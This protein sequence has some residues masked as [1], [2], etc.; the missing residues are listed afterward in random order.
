MAPALGFSSDAELRRQGSEMFCAAHIGFVEYNALQTLRL[1]AEDTKSG[2]GLGPGATVDYTSLPK[3]VPRVI[4]ELFGVPLTEEASQAVLSVA[5]TYSKQTNPRT[6][7][8]SN[9]KGE[10]VSDS[11]KKRSTAPPIFLKAA[12]KLILPNRPQVEAFTLDSAIELR[13]A[14]AAKRAEPE[15]MTADQWKAH[16]AELKTLAAAAAA[17]KKKEEEEAAGGSSGASRQAELPAGSQVSLGLSEGD[18]EIELEPG[19]E[20]GPTAEEYPKLWPLP[21]LLDEWSA[22]DPIVPGSY[23]KHASLRVFDFTDPEEVKLARAY[24]QAE[25]PFV[26]RGVPNLMRLNREWNDEYLSGA[27][28]GKRQTE[29]SESNHF[30]YYHRGAS[31]VR[32]GDYKAVTAD[33]SLTYSEWIA[34]ARKVD[35]KVLEEGAVNRETAHWYFRASGKHAKEGRAVRGSGPDPF[36]AGG[37]KIFDR[38]KPDNGDEQDIAK[39][40]FFVVDPRAQRGIHCRFGM[41]GIIAEAHYDGGRNFISMVRGA[42]RYIM[43]PPTECPHYNLLLDGPSARHSATDWGD[44]TDYKTTL[45]KA[46]AT[47]VIIRAGDALYVPSFWF[48]TP[49]SLSTN[50]QCNTRS[51]SPPEGSKDIEMCGF[52]IQVTEGGAKRTGTPKTKAPYYP[53]PT[54]APTKDVVV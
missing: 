51:G 13:R 49:I 10:F 20:G 32:K 9:A 43:S 26:A 34:K 46:K 21:E 30:M 31:A 8:N 11:E 17:Q 29:V 14:P 47:E 36:I 12:E 18:E 52:R 27:I 41:A 25:V 24:R 19:S 38:T 54:P 39:S 22:D 5:S 28:E 45:A 1:A 6:G 7:A 37:Y 16:A 53:E 50:I 23:G 40:E 35:R 2:S 15:E 4:T 33:T 44:S 42:K 48:H 3:V